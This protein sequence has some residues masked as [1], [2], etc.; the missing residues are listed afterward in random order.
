MG[1]HFEQFGQRADSTELSFTAMSGRYKIQEYGLKRSILDIIEKLQINPEDR[2]LDVGCGVG[3]ITIALSMM[4]AHTTCIDHVKVLSVFKKRLPM[5]EIDFIPGNFL[6]IDISGE[7]DKILSYGV[8]M[9]LPAAPDVIRFIDKMVCLLAPGGRMLIGDLPNINKKKRFN[10]SKIGQDF[11]KEWSQLMSDP[12]NQREIEWTIKN[13]EIPENSA[14][15]DDQF[16]SELLLRY[17]T[18][19][20]DTYI[21]QQPSDLAFGHTR[22]DL[23]IIR[24]N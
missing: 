21:L 2:L 14:I 11:A 8:V 12:D 22:E 4:V 20:F 10:E 7:F 18:Q 1:I 3:N 13:V 6:D 23:L 15:F 19:G 24:P 5:D 9:C 17:R 16:M